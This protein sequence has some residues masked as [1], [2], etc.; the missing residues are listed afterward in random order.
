[1]IKNWEAAIAV[2]LALGPVCALWVSDI[3]A[4]N[5]FVHIWPYRTLDERMAIR[6]KA[7]ATGQYP[8]NAKAVREGGKAYPMHRQENKLLMPAAFSPLQ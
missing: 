4:L 8:P 2:R 1:M 6:H 7:E 5:K 3:G